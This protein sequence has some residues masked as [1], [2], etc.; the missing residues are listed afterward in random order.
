MYPK[1]NLSGIFH[2]HQNATL[3]RCYIIKKLFYVKYFCPFLEFLCYD[4]SLCMI[5]K[6]LP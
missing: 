1:Y 2:F 6:L 4:F 3:Q 5:K